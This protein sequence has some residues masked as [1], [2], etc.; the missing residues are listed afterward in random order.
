MSTGKI[1]SVVT[2][3]FTLAALA[4]LLAALDTSTPLHAQTL[5]GFERD[6]GRMMLGII[7]DDVKKHYYDPTFRGIDIDARFKEAEEKIKQA[8]SNGQVF[9]I[10]AR[11][12]LD[13]NDSHTFFLP[14]SRAS[15]SDYGWQMQIVGDMCYVAA[16]KPGSDA[17]TKGLK[18]G[19]RVLSVNGF[20]PTRD[21]MW[22]LHYLYYSLQPQAGLRVVAESPGGQPRELDVMA[23][24]QQGKKLLDLTGSIDLNN[25]VRD[26]ES[27]DRLHRH[28][29]HEV[30]DE[31]LI[32]KMP[33]FDLEENVVDI[34]FKKK[35]I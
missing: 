25:Y 11:V 27:E 18:I 14:P 1:S 22:Q 24:V 5:S 2:R 26:A 12:L 28:R 6:R 15:R 3:V 34:A 21:N 32:W 9:R 17:E 29:F 13:F 7:K 31:L 4:S 35:K 33:Q 20:Q 23:K 10:I 8:T 30:G 19:D 16:V